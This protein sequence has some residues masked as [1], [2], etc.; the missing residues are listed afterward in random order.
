MVFGRRT[1]P[2]SQG[3]RFRLSALPGGQAEDT[4]PAADSG[5]VHAPLAMAADGPAVLTSPDQA[6]SSVV[7][8]LTAYL[9][10]VVGLPPPTVVVL[11]VSDRTLGLGNSRGLESVGAFAAV[12]LFGGQVDCVVRFQVWGAD[13]AG[14][15]TEM[16]ALQGRLLGARAEL[17]DAG[18][19]QFD[20]VAG[21]LPVADRDAFSRTADYHAL[22]EY[23]L[24]PT[25]TADSLVAAIPIEADQDL[26]GL[27]AGERTTVTDDLVRW[28]Q[29]STPALVLRGRRSVDALAVAA[30]LP[31]PQPSGEVRI[32]R[33]SDDA[34][35]APT[36]YLTLAAF[37][38]AAS[39]PVTPERNGRYS[40][41]SVAAFIVAFHLEGDL[42]L[43]D[44]DQDGNPDG[45]VVGQLALDPP[46]PLA[47]AS[48]RVEI[49]P[50]TAPLD[51]VGVV[52]LRAARALG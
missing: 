17:F 2:E 20:G 11:Q 10:P 5:P 28:D 14:A 15:N 37:L 31:S 8:T 29:N 24:A 6:V 21:T 35:T 27:L 51:H 4:P 33:T 47:A 3:K 40:F 50:Q 23:H 42:L 19:L 41:P 30:F 36:D 7:S 13:P 43:G 25:S 38:Q 16:T 9:S 52:Y 1:E 49:S 44:W 45:Y 26:A 48:D 22:V 12:E 18:F 39:D 46:I 34:T 32:V